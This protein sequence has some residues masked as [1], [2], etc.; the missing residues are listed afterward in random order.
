M[1]YRCSEPVRDTEAW[2]LGV[3]RSIK[4]SETWAAPSHGCQK[5]RGRA[6]PVTFAMFCLRGGSGVQCF[7]QRSV[8]CCVG[9]YMQSSLVLAE[10]VDP[11]R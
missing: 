9:G 6:R 7:L 8:A 4:A 3:E 11:Q 2:A 10:N 1:P 5:R